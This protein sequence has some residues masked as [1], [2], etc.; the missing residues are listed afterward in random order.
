MTSASGEAP[1]SPQ[2]PAAK[3]ARG[4]SRR[5]T[6]LVFLVLSIPTFG[7]LLDGDLTIDQ[8]AVRCLVALVVAMVGLQLLE[9][10]VGSYTRE[11]EPEPAVIEAADPDLPE[12]APAR[13]AD[14]VPEPA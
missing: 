6:P 7:Q 14:D 1:L 2:A 12:P 11:P 13:R 8:A 3:P 4:W 10:L 5:A 9:G